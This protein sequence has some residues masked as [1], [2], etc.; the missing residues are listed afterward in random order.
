M[1]TIQVKP[2]SRQSKCVSMCVYLCVC[3][4]LCHHMA[5]VIYFS[6]S[7]SNDFYFLH[8]I[9]IIFTTIYTFESALKVTARGFIMT[10]FTYLRDPWNWLD[11]IVILF[12]YLTMFIS[13]L[14][15]LSALRSFRVLRA[16]KTVAII[17]G[18]W[19]IFSLFPPLLDAVDFAILNLRQDYFCIMTLVN[20]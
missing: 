15:N 1:K 14:G 12:A 7:A 20:D 11:F 18:Q 4:C 8:F 16:L 3:L 13:E 10:K 2:S 6:T 19:L 17:P 9:R 5:R